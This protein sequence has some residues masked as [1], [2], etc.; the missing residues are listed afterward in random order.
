VLW[1]DGAREELGVQVDQVMQ[2]LRDRSPGWW[3]WVCLGCPPVQVMSWVW[4]YLVNWRSN[5]EWRRVE[6]EV[7][8]KL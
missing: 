8:A 6:G 3:T 1:N 7:K 2:R 5:R 4:G